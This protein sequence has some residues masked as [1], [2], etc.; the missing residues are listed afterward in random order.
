M[1][2]KEVETLFEAV[3]CT[4]PK[5]TPEVRKVFS[6]LVSSTLRYRD[7]MKEQAGITVTVEDVRVTLDMLLQVLHTKMVPH[8][9]LAVRANLLELWLEELA[10]YL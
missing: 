5:T 3:A 10:P 2:D 7:Q 4:M 1:N 6:L 8:Q 9:D